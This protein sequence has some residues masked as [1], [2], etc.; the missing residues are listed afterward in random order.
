MLLLGISDSGRC[1][2]GVSCQLF[3]FAHEQPETHQKSLLCC[4]WRGQHGAVAVQHAKVQI[5]LSNAPL[6]FAHCRT[7]NI[8]PLGDFFHRNPLPQLGHRAEDVLHIIALAR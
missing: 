8:V 5:A 4:I 3:R 7:G 2:G 1:H 6:P